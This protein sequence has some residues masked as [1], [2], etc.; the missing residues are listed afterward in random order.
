[1]MDCDKAVMLLMGHLDGELDDESQQA[2]KAHLDGCVACRREEKAYR[3]LTAMTE[4]IEFVEPTE[5]E[6]RA[7]WEGVYNQCERG[8]AWILLSLGAIILLACGI[9]Q[10]I[11][12]FLLDAAYPL[13]LRLGVGVA[14]AGTVV[15]AVS[16]VRERI[17]LYSV[18]RYEEVEL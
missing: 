18:D 4:S 3:R 5:A 2:L 1:M 7:H 6:W 9:W 15:L 11:A 13:M 14:S 10:L 16:V 8:F 17:R 12:E